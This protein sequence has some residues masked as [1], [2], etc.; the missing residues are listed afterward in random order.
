MADQKMKFERTVLNGTNKVGKLKADADGYYRVN[1]GAFEA[2]NAH[3]TFYTFNNYLKNMFSQGS[4]LQQRISAGR[5]RGEVEHPQMTPGQNMAQY[6]NRLRMIDGRN[7]ICH[8]KDVTATAAKDH[9]GRD[10]ILVEASV[11]PSGVK[12]D[13]LLD[14]LSNNTRERLLLCSYYLWRASSKWPSGSRGT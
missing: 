3:G 13:V 7:T 6:F 11:R 12:R 4:L 8:F 1:L 2:Y 9:E 10:I 5:L 14:Q